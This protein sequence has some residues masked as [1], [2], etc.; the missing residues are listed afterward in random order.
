MNGAANVIILAAVFD[1][2]DQ[3]SAIAQMI[4]LLVNIK[5]WQNIIGYGVLMSA[6]ERKHNFK[7]GSE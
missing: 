2:E 4:E 6:N 1:I 5:G 3:C 7:G